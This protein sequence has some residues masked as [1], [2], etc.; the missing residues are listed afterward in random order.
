[1]LLVFFIILW[2][3]IYGSMHYYIYKKIVPYCLPYKKS[4]I[5]VLSLLASSIFVVEL[6]SFTDFARSAYRFANIAYSWMGLVFIF[7]VLSGTLDL[8]SLVLRKG[9][10]I[11]TAE[12]LNA[13]QRTPFV[14]FIVIGLSVLGYMQARQINIETIELTSKKITQP[15]R[16]VQ[17]ADLH[18]GVQSDEKHIRGIVNKINELKPDIIVATG[19]LL[20][21]HFG[22]TQRLSEILSGL[23]APLG[24]Y[25]IYGNHEAMMGQEES[26]QLIE[27]A[28]FTVLA[29]EGVSP[30]NLL[31]LVGVN[32]PAVT[33]SLKIDN[34]NEVLTLQTFSKGLYTVL[35]KHQPRFNPASAPYFDLQL[36]GHTHGG[37]IFPFS[38]L[39]RLIYPLG[40]GLSKVDINTWVYVSQGIGTWGPPMR[41]G[42]KPEINVFDI[43][44]ID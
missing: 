3:S 36:S 30:H 28:G 12:I 31:T 6:L 5:G 7:V 34:R 14:L 32:D 41:L 23:K 22:H 38:L 20:E 26:R 10:F 9:K 42:A 13:K 37:Q 8:L 2:L 43:R 4:L 19:D 27:A 40:F 25:A 24:K 39:T 33:A 29:N 18:T 35:L 44:N 17:I 1:M 15:L 11:K 21:I 16:I